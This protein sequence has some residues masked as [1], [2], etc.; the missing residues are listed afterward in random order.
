MIQE[1]RFQITKVL[2]GA[3]CFTQTGTRRALLSMLCAATV[4]GYASAQTFSPPAI[5]EALASGVKPLVII[6]SGPAGSAAALYGGLLGIP[7]TVITGFLKGGQLMQTSFIENYPG[8]K[9][10]EGKALMATMHE[11]AQDFNAELI[12]DEIVSV[13]FSTWPFVLHG[14]VNDYRALAVIATTGATPKKLEIPGE[15]TYWGRGVSSCA[16][17]DGHFFKDKDVVVVGG[18]DAA[19]EEA[20]QLAPNARSITIL[21]RS[22]R[23]R[24]VYHMQEKL[25]GYRTIKVVYNKQVQEVLGDEQG[26]TGLEIVDTMTGKKERMSVDGLFLAIGHHSHT[27][28]FQGQLAL[29]PTGHITLEGRSQATS[30]TGIYAAGDVE[31][32]LCRQAI[33]AAGHGAQAAIEA[34][35]WLREMG[36]TQNL[37]TKYFSKPL[38]TSAPDWA[39]A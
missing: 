3:F 22:S 5:E 7:T 30:V 20:M 6:G 25:Q 38:D 29:R 13:D 19:V 39:V 27:E 37:V 10:I 33:V 11:Q 31:D 15:E 9:R 23:M 12:E 21:V 4:L 14:T 17:C 16:K 8:V 28:L 18:G 35:A 34:V 1:K 2:E 24:A 26:V 32:D 36:L